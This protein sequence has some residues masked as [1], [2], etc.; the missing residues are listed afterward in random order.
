MNKEIKER[1]EHFLT[2]YDTHTDYIYLSGPINGNPNYIED[3]TKAEKL[4]RMAGYND[5]INPIEF[6]TL[7]EDRVKSP[8]HSDY[9]YDDL[10][11]MFFFRC[12]KIAVVTTDYDSYGMYMETIVG[13]FCGMEVKSVGA[14]VHESIK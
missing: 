7:T 6:N 12:K 5:I 3:F 9:M 8:Q 13:K 10:T 1:V 14:W 4:L 2:I 11:L